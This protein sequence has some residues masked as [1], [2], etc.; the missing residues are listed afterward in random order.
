[1]YIL[2]ASVVAGAVLGC[3]ILAPRLRGRFF[4]SSVHPVD[5]ADD[6]AVAYLIAMVLGGVSLGVI[7]TV[8]MKLL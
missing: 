1:M 4:Q 8:I 7:S 6:T 2:S 3:R 5:Q